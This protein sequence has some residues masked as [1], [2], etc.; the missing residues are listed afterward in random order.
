MR[1]E[2][3]HM[4]SSAQATNLL[5][6]FVLAIVSAIEGI[7]RF[8]Y[9]EIRVIGNSVYVFMVVNFPIRASDGFNKIAGSFV[10]GVITLFVAVEIAIALFPSVATGVNSLTSGASAPLTGTGATLVGQIPLFLA[11]ALLL[12]AVGFAVVYVRYIRA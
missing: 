7:S 12:V 9:T 4:Q 6:L 3:T 1:S 5:V 2:L 10:G 8:T 11:L